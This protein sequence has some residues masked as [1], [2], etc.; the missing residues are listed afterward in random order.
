MQ[1][2][3]IVFAVSSLLALPVLADSAVKQN[4]AESSAE[5]K[6]PAERRATIDKTAQDTLAQVYKKFPRAK[7]QIAKASAYA[8]FRTGGFQAVFVGAGG[9]DGVAVASGKRTYMDML[10]GKVGL[11]LGA[12][13]TREVWVF[14]SNEAYN[15]FIT[16]GWSASGEAGAAAKAGKAGGQ[17]TG[18]KHLAKD[19]YVYQ[20]TENGLSAEATVNG[21]KY[22]VN[23]DLNK[24]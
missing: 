23:S 3:S 12:K 4:S 5:Q 9:G 7:A 18:A 16:S 6:T 24:K 2:R 17:I 14:T 15:K 1:L 13:E 11:G 21:A 19:V 20:F 22:L 8:V 10:Q